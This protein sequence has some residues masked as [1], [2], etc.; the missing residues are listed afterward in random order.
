MKLSVNN[1][2]VL[3]LFS[4]IL[5]TSLNA[6]DPVFKTYLINRSKSDANFS[7]GQDIEKYQWI[8]ADSVNVVQHRINSDTCLKEPGYK[9]APNESIL[10]YK[11][12][13]GHPDATPKYLRVHTK[14]SCYLV[15][16]S[17]ITRRAAKKKLFSYSYYIE[18]N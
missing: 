6:C 3:I 12:T 16:A 18:L 17:E 4:G 15:P 9:I 14:D 1:R 2:I 10:L 5:V 7:T 11:L 8:R 13:A